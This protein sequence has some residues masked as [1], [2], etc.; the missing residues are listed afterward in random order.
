MS[1]FHLRVH[2]L[3]LFNFSKTVFSGF[4]CKSDGKR[5]KQN[6]RE[7]KHRQDD[8]VKYKER[9]NYYSLMDKM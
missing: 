8:Y 9:E 4:F 6:E 1:G 5:E 3:G 7:R 2:S